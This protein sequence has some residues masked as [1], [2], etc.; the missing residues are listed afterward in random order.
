[1]IISSGTLCEKYKVL[2][3]VVAFES[4]TA[5]CG[6]SIKVEKAYKNALA[7]LVKSAEAKE[8]D[9]IINVNFQNRVATVAVGCGSSG[10]AFEVFAWGTAVKVVE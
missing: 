7:S 6:S 5:G 9:A 1:M 4:Q 2:D 3:L 10:Q 8:A